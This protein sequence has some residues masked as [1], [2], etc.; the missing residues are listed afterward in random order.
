MVILE[1]E[2]TEACSYYMSGLYYSYILRVFLMKLLPKY[3]DA[4]YLLSLHNNSST[5]LLFLGHLSS[6]IAQINQFNLGV[7]KRVH[8]LSTETLKAQK[9]QTATFIHFAPN[10]TIPGVCC[11]METETRDLDTLMCFTLLEFI[12]LFFQGVA[13]DS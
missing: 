10:Q 6:P 9:A 12:Q 2:I 4:I 7:P 13:Y 1:V 3:P 5:Y 11:Q 8:Q